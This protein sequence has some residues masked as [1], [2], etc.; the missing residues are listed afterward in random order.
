MET[1]KKC[2]VCGEVK[3][4]EEFYPKKGTKDGFM[5]RCK[6]CDNESCKKYR[7]KNK[8]K[9]KKK[10]KQYRENNKEKL[11]IKSREAWNKN[12]D[13]RNK[14][15]RENRKP[16]TPEQKERRK[17]F[18]EEHKDENR[19][20][21]KLWRRKKIKSDPIFKCIAGLRHGIWSSLNRAGYKKK[22]KTE[23]ILGCDWEFFKEYI[24]SKFTYGMSWDNYG[25]WHFDHIMPISKARTE[26]EAEKLCYYTNFQPL[27]ARDNLSK[28][29]HVPKNIQLKLL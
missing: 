26:E 4:L 19:V 8:D 7:E 23:E 12:K 25:D 15:R 3:L 1:K 17:L 10:S 6:K 28:W 13:K 14:Q 22:D 24:E 5:W 21:Q 29:A 16:M 27:W 18:M 2:P 20:Y 11:L 9:L